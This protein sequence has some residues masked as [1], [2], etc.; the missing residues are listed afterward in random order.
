M[1]PASVPNGPSDI[2]TYALLRRAPSR[3]CI[4]GNMRRQAA[5]R[6]ECASHPPN[7]NP[8]Q[9]PAASS[10]HVPERTST[11]TRVTPGKGH[12]HR[13]AAVHG[14]PVLPLHV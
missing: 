2:G 4:V 9:R 3:K 1:R 7:Q 10:G 5:A 14:G 8:Q 6:R 13:P 11:W 12:H